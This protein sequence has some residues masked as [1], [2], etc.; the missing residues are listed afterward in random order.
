MTGATR[1]SPARSSAGAVRRG[2]QHPASLPSTPWG[3]PSGAVGPA[4]SPS[5][6]AQENLCSMVT[7]IS[8]RD[9]ELVSGITFS[10]TKANTRFST[11]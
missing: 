1:R 10:R 4:D 6:I 9:I 7:S 5:G 8:S 2:P 11:A 3:D